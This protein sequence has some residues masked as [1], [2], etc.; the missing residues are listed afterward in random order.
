MAGQRA[1]SGTPSDLGEMR[2]LASEQATERSLYARLRLP[3]LLAA[4]AATVGG[5]WFLDHLVLLWVGFLQLLKG[6][7]LKKL[8]LGAWVFVAPLLKRLVVLEIPKKVLT[9]LAWIGLGS[10]ARRWLRARIRLARIRLGVIR[11]HIEDRFRWLTGR[12]IALLISIAATLAIFLIGLFGFGVYLVWWVGA[13]RIPASLIGLFGKAGRMVVNVLFK[14]FA[15]LNLNKA[16]T[17]LHDR[18]PQE[19]GYRYRLAKRRFLRA[20]SSRGRLTLRRAHGRLARI[21]RSRRMRLSRK[22]AG[23][24]G[25]EARRPVRSEP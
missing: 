12:H 23:S 8:W 18:V 21:R 11:Q 15:F 22:R 4:L 9:G 17:F 6:L 16:W 3:F 13:I 24:S 25:V 14:T 2:P 7:T 19:I 20:T 5:W 10:D 1:L